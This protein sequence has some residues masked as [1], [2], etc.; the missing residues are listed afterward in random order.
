[1]GEAHITPEP[2]TSAEGLPESYRRWRASRLGRAVDALELRLIL[3]VAGDVSGL[4]VLD[5]GC[6]DGVLALQLAAAGARVFG[7]DADSRMIAEARRRQEAEGGDASF[8]LGTAEAL[9]FAD[10]S[11]D[12]VTSI[13]MLCLAKEPSR[14]VREMARVLSPAGRVLIGEL[15]RFS[16]WAA[17]RRVRG[18]LGSSR[19][20]A[21]TFWSAGALRALADGAGLEVIDLRGAIFF[22]PV[23]WLAAPM[24]G[25][26]LAIGRH[27]TFGAAFVTMAA[28]RAV[29]P[30]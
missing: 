6:G 13:A 3:E 29:P 28:R 8:L 22:P 12:L 26:D 24:G 2:M 1:M 16:L 27:A 14:A 19:W 7:L 5:V 21:A 25:I 11:F 15:G 10:A 23:G 9:P 20:K 17:Q 4:R 18:W 30:G